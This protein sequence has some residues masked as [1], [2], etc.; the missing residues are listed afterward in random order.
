MIKE[1][2]IG[3]MTCAACSASVERAVRRVQGVDAASVNL[4]TERLTVRSETD[5]SPAVFAAVEKTG[6]TIS[7]VESI[8]KQSLLE[9]ER[10][11]K[12]MKQRK[13]NLIIALAFTIPLF[14][15]SM[16]HMVGLPI[17][18]FMT[19]PKVFSLVQIILLIP[20]IYAGRG[21]YVRGFKAIATLHPN[22][23]SLIALGTIAAI[24]YSIYSTVLIFTGHH[25]MMHEG[26]Y[27]ESAGVIITLVMLGKYLEQRAKAKTGDAVAALIGLTPDT[28]RIVL[29]DGSE[30]MINADEI[31]VGERIRVLPGERIPVDGK[32]VEGYSSVDESMLSGESIPVDK[33]VGDSVV[34]GSVNM[35]GSFIYVSERVGDDTVLAGMIRMVEQAQGSK[36]PIARLA[37]KISGVFVPTVTV[38]AIV[39]ALIWLF[40]GETIG[41]A[42]KIMVSVLVIACPCALG[43]ATP[44]TIMVGMGRGAGMGIFIKNGEALE[45]TCHVDTIVL[46]KTGTITCG[47]PEVMRTIPHNMD[48]EEFLR[49]FASAESG[50]EHP[51]A[52]A[53]TKYVSD[54]GIAFSP[55]QSYTALVGRGGEASVNGK[56]V[57]VGNER[58]MV[59]NKIDFDKA[60]LDEI[61]DSGSTPLMLAVDGSYCGI[62]GVADAVKP[63]SKD[64]IAQLRDAGIDVWLVTGDNERTAKNVA[65]QVGINN[66][67][68]SCLPEDKNTFIGEL[69][70]RGKHVAMVGDGIN[71]AA[72]LAAADVGIAIGTGTDVAVASADIVLAKGEL[73]GISNAIR[74]SR[75]TLRIIKQNLFW[76][77]AYNC[78]GIPIAAGLLHAFGGPLLNPMIAAL[79][80]SLSSVTVLTN[81]LRLKAIKLK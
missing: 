37:D 3:G 73:G 25:E 72:A 40:A 13:Q 30:K 57:L 69:R 7:N 61:T 47:K 8:K 12:D 46:D 24:G 59:E 38:I 54:K 50:S 18:K 75:T 60:A 5:L 33:N 45:H 78:L 41:V 68:S 1:Y 4:S 14:Y 80:M 66:I 9:S 32:I 42:I 10:R 77:F 28:A 11:R 27:Y 65:A 70:E 31:V 2:S 62:I 21:F 22:M 67:K 53:V 56:K 58:L 29:K 23:D 43:L 36:A 6:F 79:A 64:A 20:V 44:T 74:L 63:D 39:S 17:P 34:G 35:N 16:G 55:P 19:A 15:I 71:D 48:S 76:A 49:V 26:L 51:L 52:A 81:A